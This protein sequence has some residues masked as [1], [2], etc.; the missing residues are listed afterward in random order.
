M[1]LPFTCAHVF[2]SGHRHVLRHVIRTAVSCDCASYSSRCSLALH[3]GAT[4]FLLCNTYH[5]VYE[6]SSLR[7]AVRS[8]STECGSVLVDE[9]L[10]LAVSEV[11]L[12]LVELSCSHTTLMHQARLAPIPRLPILAVWSFSRSLSLSLKLEICNIVL[13]DCATRGRASAC[14]GLCCESSFGSSVLVFALVEKL[15]RN[16]DLFLK[17]FDIT[18]TRC[19]QGVLIPPG[20]LL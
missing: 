6:V 15:L 9:A 8:L 18:S 3:A 20:T 13:G 17:L 14:S 7:V 11:C 10:Y 5:L 12:G 1:P 4:L 19:F 16:L 2:L